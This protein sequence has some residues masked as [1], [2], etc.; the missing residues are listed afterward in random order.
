MDG[1][2][3]HRVVVDLGEDGLGHPGPLGVLEVG[4]GQE[5]TQ[6]P[7]EGVGELAR[8][9]GD[10][11]EPAPRLAG[12]LLV[13]GQR[14]QRALGEHPLDQRAHVEPPAVPVEL[15]QGALAGRHRVVGPEGARRRLPVVPAAPGPVEPVEVVV[16]APEE[17]GAQGGHHGDLVGR[18]VDRSQH[19]QQVL[20][21]GGGV[22]ERAALEPEGEVGVLEG[23][24][25]DGQAG[26]GRDQHGDVGQGG[27][28]ALVADRPPLGP[29]PPDG[30]GDVLRTRVGG[31]RR[32]ARRSRSRPR[33][34]P[35]AGGHRD[36]PGRRG[37]RR[38]AGRPAACPARHR[39]SARRRPG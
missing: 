10:E 8:L 25:Q 19:A 9:V 12:A 15:G 21:L 37:G 5:A 18:V 23:A 35:P 22:H 30:P 26:P 6:I 28:P 16:A 27:R 2:D 13:E 3:P 31:P 7:P 39:R 38:A 24:L 1:H 34:P 14:H 11:A 33:G 32:P 4:P 36:P 20:H 29:D 17:G